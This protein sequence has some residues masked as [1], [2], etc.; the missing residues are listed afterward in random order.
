MI[1]FLN[2]TE[3]VFSVKT[4]MENPAEPRNGLKDFTKHYVQKIIQSFKDLHGN[5]HYLALGMAI[6]VFVGM[7]PTFPL[8]TAIAVPISHLFRGSKRAA[9]LGVWISNP[10]TL[11]FCYYAAYKLGMFLMDKPS[12]FI[13]LNLNALSD[14]LDLGIEVAGAMM[15]GGLVLGVICGISAYA[16]THHIARV[17][18]S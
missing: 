17:T 7:T 4:K 9:M 11:P 3:C 12:P 6:G 10:V 13:S 14:V 18:R 1:I 5:P 15:L 2:L 16:V 8:H